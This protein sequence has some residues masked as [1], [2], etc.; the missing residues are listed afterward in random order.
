MGMSKASDAKANAKHAPA[1]FPG[2]LALKALRDKHASTGKLADKPVYDMTD[3]EVDALIA[4]KKA[5]K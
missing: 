3:A 4:A 5:A 2:D 1:P